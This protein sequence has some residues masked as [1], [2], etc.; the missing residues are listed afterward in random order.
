[1]HVNAP[2]FGMHIL[3]ATVCLLYTNS[4][5]ILEVPVPYYLVNP[6]LQIHKLLIAS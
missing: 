3:T 6:F 2:K 1:M 5:I 4:T